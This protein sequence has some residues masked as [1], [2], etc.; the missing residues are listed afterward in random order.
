M[1]RLTI[2]IGVALLSLAY[3]GFALDFLNDPLIADEIFFVQAADN[4][5]RNGAPITRKREN[6]AMFST[7][8]FSS[9]LNTKSPE[10]TYA[11]WH[12]PFYIYALAAI[13]KFA[14]TGAMQAR[15]LGLASFIA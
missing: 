12:P 5:S 3:I 4:L 14:G 2:I 15:L 13:F 1:R 9:Q 10:V 7:P 8:D 11:L 6:L